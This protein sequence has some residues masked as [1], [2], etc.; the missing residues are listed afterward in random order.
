[1]NERRREPRVWVPGIAVLRSGAQ[2]PTVWR[3]SNLSTGGAALEGDGT[4]AP[5]PLWM[6]LHVAGFEGLDL[7]AKVLRRQLARSGRAGVRFVELTGEQREA[8]ADI[9][10]AVHAP[11]LVRR[12]ALVVIPDDK[13]APGLTAELTAIGFAVRRETS[14]G[15]AAAWLQKEGAELLLVDDSAVEADRWSLL[16][17]AHDTVPETR[18]LVL[19]Q[20]VRGFRLYYAIKAGWVE[21][22]VEPTMVGDTLARHLLASA[23]P[24]RHAI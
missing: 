8:L 1:M 22:L 2:A 20:D 19:A 23:P 4:L 21:G 10:S 12:R 6:T 7:R 13:R 11:A 17:F 9:V 5:G 18:R 15:Q 16:Q 3:V 14:P 24:R